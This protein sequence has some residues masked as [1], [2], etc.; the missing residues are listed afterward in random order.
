MSRYVFL[1]LPRAVAADPE[2]SGAK[3]VF[4]LF[5]VCLEPFHHHSG[6]KYA[7]QV[8]VDQTA[9]N[10]GMFNASDFLRSPLNLFVADG[11]GANTGG[12]HAIIDKTQQG[13]HRHT[14]THEPSAFALIGMGAIGL[15]GYHRRK[16]KQAA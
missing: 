16:R 6:P 15:I 2:I 5:S 12:I 11:A 4:C 1:I 8:I 3:L 9:P 13:V 7:S 14:V 10:I